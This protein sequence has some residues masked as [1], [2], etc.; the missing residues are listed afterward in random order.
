MIVACQHI[1]RRAGQMEHGAK[2]HLRNLT[3]YFAFLF[4]FA[5]MGDT[6]TRF[7]LAIECITTMVNFYLSQIP[8]N[9]S[10]FSSEMLWKCYFFVLSI[11]S[12]FRCINFSHRGSLSIFICT[13]TFV[14]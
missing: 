4:E 8:E 1:L 9:V 10:P 14:S 13:S 12:H 2:S 3:E 11:L 6:E 5:K 7:L